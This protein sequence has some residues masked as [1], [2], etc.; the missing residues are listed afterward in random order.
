[1]DKGL[2]PEE[3]LLKLIKDGAKSDKVNESTNHPSSEQ[4][5]PKPQEDVN[6]SIPQEV[7]ILDAP[8]KKAKNKIFIKIPLKKFFSIGNLN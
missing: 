4:K 5:T 2:T 7:A 3:R 6:P 8:F 1:M